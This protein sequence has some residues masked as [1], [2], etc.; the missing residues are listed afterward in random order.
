ML[1]F[2]LRNPKNTARWLEERSRALGASLGSLANPQLPLQPPCEEGRQGGTRLCSYQEVLHSG[3]WRLEVENISWSEPDFTLKANRIDG[4]CWSMHGAPSRDEVSYQQGEEQTMSGEAQPPWGH[5]A[6]CTAM[7]SALTQAVLGAT[8]TPACSALQQVLLVQLGQ[9]QGGKGSNDIIAYLGTW[10]ST[11]TGHQPKI[12]HVFTELLKCIHLPVMSP[13][14]KRD[15]CSHPRALGHPS[16][17][18]G[19]IASGWSFSPATDIEGTKCSGLWCPF[20]RRVIN[21]GLS[22]WGSGFSCTIVQE[23]N[24]AFFLLRH[25]SENTFLTSAI[26][27]IAVWGKCFSI[28]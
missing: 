3:P 23:S 10:S 24:W 21:C 14:G 11:S 5:Q 19:W 2:Q 15:G 28:D 20:I 12:S 26:G 9:D 25:T 1:A 18:R 27:K 22:A 16:P 8:Q 13:V 17:T 4:G 7:E 6:A